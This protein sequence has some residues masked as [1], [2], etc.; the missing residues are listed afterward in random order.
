MST[1]TSTSTSAS[2]EESTSSL[3]MTP[4]REAAELLGELFPE[5]PAP[6]QKRQW[7][8]M[9]P[10]MDGKDSRTPVR[11]APDHRNP[12]LTYWLGLTAAVIFAAIVI[13]IGLMRRA[14]V[15][16]MMRDE[17]R[18]TPHI[19]EKETEA[20]LPPIQYSARRLGIVG[21]TDDKY[22]LPTG[23]RKNEDEDNYED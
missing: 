3:K 22:N 13:G 15:K 18:A 7:P 2:E 23:K 5:T 16:Q 12:N 20:Y 21:V 9:A 6:T 19:P 8:V 4:A 10:T 1:T 11:D 14:P 17:Q